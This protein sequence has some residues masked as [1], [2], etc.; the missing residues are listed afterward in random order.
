L[1]VILIPRKSH[2]TN[3]RNSAI[4]TKNCFHVM[5]LAIMIPLR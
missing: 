4:A 3:S 1:D 2:T 5:K